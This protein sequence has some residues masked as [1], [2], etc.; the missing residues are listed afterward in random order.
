[1]TARLMHN[2]RR[3]EAQNGAGERC[4]RDD[5][6]HA[7][8]LHRFGSDVVAMTPETEHPSATRPPEIRTGYITPED[9][10]GPIF[11]VGSTT[12]LVCAKA[13]ADC[14]C[15]DDARLGAAVREAMRLVPSGFRIDVAW[16]CVSYNRALSRDECTTVAPIMLALVD[17]RRELGL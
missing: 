11:R 10:D 14:R 6:G 4:L 13:V 1:M 15:R 2:G 12:C 9:F 7:P 16:N 17:V 3:C 5:D 8:Y